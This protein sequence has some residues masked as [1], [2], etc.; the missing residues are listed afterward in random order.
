[1][2]QAF[3]NSEHLVKDVDGIVVNAVRCTNFRTK[4][5]SG[6]YPAN[7][8]TLEYAF[9]IVLRLPISATNPERKV[10]VIIDPDGQNLGPYP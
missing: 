9:N 2:N 1:M 7:T 6:Q 4:T 10:T 3:Y 5:D 8:E